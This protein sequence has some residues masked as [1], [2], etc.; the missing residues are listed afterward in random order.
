M[1]RR[2]RVAAIKPVQRAQNNRHTQQATAHKVPL[3]FSHRQARIFTL[4]ER[5]KWGDRDRE[6]VAATHPPGE[7]KG[8]QKERE[9]ERGIGSKQA[10]AGK[11][12][13]PLR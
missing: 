12:G 3:S 9:R 8:S 1:S 11:I 7:R 2:R 4:W 13:N 5:K 10:K 6:G